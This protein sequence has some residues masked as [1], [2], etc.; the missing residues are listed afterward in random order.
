MIRTLLV[1][2]ILPAL[3]FAQLID[4]YV[5]PFGGYSSHPAYTDIFFSDSCLE[6][7]HDELGINQFMGGGFTGYHADRFASKGI[8]VYPW[9]TAPI[10]RPQQ[11]YAHSTYYI[12]DAEDDYSDFK[13]ETRNGT[14]Q[15][16]TVLVYDGDDF[17]L[18]GLYFRQENRQWMMGDAQIRYYP[19]LKMMIERDTSQTD[20]STVVG[21]FYVLN[22]EDSTADSMRFADTLFVRDLPAD[23]DTLVLLSLTNDWDS[24]ITYSLDYYYVL[25]NE[26]SVD[27]PKIKFRF[28]TAGNCTVFIDYF[29][30]HC[31]FGYDLMGDNSDSTIANQIKAYV[32]RKADFDGKVLGWYLKDEPR[33]GN[34]RPYGYIDSLIQVAM[35]ESSWTEPV[36]ATTNFCLG[37]G[38]QAY[39]GL[40]D[41]IRDGN[42]NRIWAN[43]YC[44]FGGFG[45]AR[46][47]K[48]TGYFHR[49]G[50]PH[51]RGL[52]FE[53]NESLAEQCDSLMASLARS[54]IEDS[55][56]MFTPQYFAGRDST[57]PGD[58]TWIWRFPTRSE[59]ICETFIGL[60][61]RPMGIMFWKY[62]QNWYY[63]KN[64]G[65]RGLV[66]DDG[67]H[68]YMYDVVKDD[69]NPYIKAIDSTFLSLTWKGSYVVS[70]S[71]GLGLNPPDTAFIDT[72]YAVSNDTLPNPDLGWFQAGE[73][74]S[75]SDKYI[76]LVN[77]ACSQGENDST[78]APSITATVKFD[79]T[80]LGLG[81]YV[82]IIDLADSLRLAGG[83]TGW[84]AIPDTTYSAKMP[85]GTIPFTTVLGPGEGRLFKIV[86]TH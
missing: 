13:F 72:I 35:A 70:D 41:F 26:N 4:E 64:S 86:G 81:N 85:D 37:C 82:Y 54:E 76:L 44:F 49:Q 84:V 74:I 55:S 30:V 16:D 33:P 69:I 66:N 40:N 50:T 68:H 3:C 22:M 42:P 46:T 67:S 79:P 11:K 57:G 34:Y 62:D 36:R 51:E 47:T 7:M 75:G 9:G 25:D 58:T 77:R 59:M 61:Y 78:A 8:Y 52:Q 63:A 18:D 24:S 17:M 43:P 31:Q 38:G 32:G 14:V 56:W 83:D 20:S 39:K 10:M 53:F 48:Y 73:F 19:Y 1:I 65:S 60:C 6:V 27:S 80:D 15:G 45:G 28:K 29:K 71:A 23:E 12:C 21:I 5:M 2:L